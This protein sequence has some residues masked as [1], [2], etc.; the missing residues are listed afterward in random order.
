MMEKVCH[1]PGVDERG[2]PS[3]VLLRP[4][5]MVKTASPIHPE[6][7]RFAENLPPDGGRELHVLLNAMGAAEYYGQ[8]I[9]RDLFDEHNRWA[10]SDDP[11]VKRAHQCLINDGPLWGHKTFEHYAHAFAHHQNKDPDKGFGHV[12]LAVWN[13]GMK[14]VELIVAIDREK[15]AQVGAQDVVDQLDRG[16]HPDWSMGCKVPWDRCTCHGDTKEAHVRLRS[17]LRDHPNLEPGKAIK[18]AHRRDPI[19]GVALTRREYC[20]QMK[21]AA[22]TVRPDGIQVGVHNDFPRFFDIS[23]VYIGADRIAKTTVPDMA[24]LANGDMVE[25]LRDNP[26]SAHKDGCG[27]GKCR[28]AHQGGEVRTKTASLQLP[29]D[30]AKKADKEKKIP[31]EQE[32]VVGRMSKV[33]TAMKRLESRE[34][35]LPRKVLNHLGSLPLSRAL[36]TTSMMGMVLKPREFQRVALI[37]KGKPGLADDLERS[38][39]VFRQGPASRCARPCGCMCCKASKVDPFDSDAITIKI[40]LPHMRDRSAFAPMLSRRIVR[41]IKLPHRP[42][43]QAEVDHPLLNKLGSAYTAYREGLMDVVPQAARCAT[44]EAVVIEALMQH[45]LDD[46]FTGSV[47]TAAPMGALDKMLIAGVLPLTYLLAAHVRGK[48]DRGDRVGLIQNFVEQHP[49]LASMLLIGAGRG[50]SSVR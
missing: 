32:D 38:G 6:I 49:I 14:R 35:D 9:N 1:C 2:D 8:N 19:P 10:D 46:L 50:V 11:L 20:D 27:C 40:M 18:L 7:T 36:G 34:P 30:L 42:H 24:K 26:V 37:G 47:K 48:K 43:A 33:R 13:D 41:Q 31:L 4:G 29:P 5:R 25:W 39:N 17:A 16:D 23:R 44:N 21:T 22:G 3:V 12:K 45:G 15:A 28:R